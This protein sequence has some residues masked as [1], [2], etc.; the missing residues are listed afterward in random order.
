MSPVRVLALAAVLYMAPAIAAEP[1]PTED[2]CPEASAFVEVQG[3]QDAI[4]RDE[5]AREIRVQEVAREHIAG[6]GLLAVLNQAASRQVFDPSGE[7]LGFEL[8][9]FDRG[10][11]FETVGLREHDVVTHLDGN[12]LTDPRR[13]VDLLRYVRELDDFTV[14]I[15]RGQ[16]LT[17]L[18][19]RV[20]VL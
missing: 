15:R 20:L 6:D 19:Y 10:S 5:G 8:Y 12:P 3:Y 14:T 7:P 13:A 1:P 11:V 9:D 2:A 17:P 18:I 16:G 4:D